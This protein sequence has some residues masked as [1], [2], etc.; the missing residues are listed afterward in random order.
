LGDPTGSNATA[1][2]ALRVTGTHKLLYHGKVEIPIKGL[3]IVVIRNW[4]A[5]VR[6]RKE[7]RRILLEAKVDNEL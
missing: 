2:F 5:V 3:K 7:W 6:D 4:H 1:G